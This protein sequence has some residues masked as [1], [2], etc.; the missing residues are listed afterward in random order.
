[1]SLLTQGEKE[2]IAQQWI[3]NWLKKEYPNIVTEV[4]EFIIVENT[5]GKV[6]RCPIQLNDIDVSQK[7]QALPSPHTTEL[8]FVISDKE[9]MRLWV[10]YCPECRTIYYTIQDL[11]EKGEG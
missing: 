10:G 5:Q 11:P 7:E 6:I 8:K 1:M 9:T 3:R 4:E 2:R